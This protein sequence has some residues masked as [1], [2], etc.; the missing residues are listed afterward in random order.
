MPRLPAAERR[1][2]LVESAIAVMAEH[3]LE[4]AS[5]HRIAQ[6]AGVSQG[7]VHYAFADKAA[8]LAAVVEAVAQRIRDRLAEHPDATV[9]ELLR[10]FWRYVEETPD[11]QRLQYE[12]TTHA[13]RDPETA[14][15]AQRQYEAYLDILETAM[16]PLA[17]GV[18]GAARRRRARLVLA[19]LDGL[20]LQWVVFRDR[21]V[22]HASLED[23]A[24]LVE[25]IAS[26]PSSCDAR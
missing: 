17:P 26:A 10:A 25:S 14:W 20:I 5:T 12:L 6:H 3:G 23:L 1:D 22:A 2:Q 8:L 18:P 19:A 4:R 11:L 21:K 13:M 15:L 24:A 16:R 9:D 7:I